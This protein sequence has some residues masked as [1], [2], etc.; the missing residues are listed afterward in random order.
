MVSLLRSLAF[1]IGTRQISVPKA[2]TKPPIHIQITSGRTKTLSVAWL[3]FNFAEAGENQIDIFAQA[4][5]MH[6]AADGR[7]LGR[8]KFQ[9]RGHD[10]FVVAIVKHA[11]GAFDAEMGRLLRAFETLELDPVVADIEGLSL[12][13]RVASFSTA[14][15]HRAGD[16][17]HDQDHAEMNHQAAVAP[18]IAPGQG[19]QTAQD[20]FAGDALA[21]AQRKGGVVKDRGHDEG[22]QGKAQKRQKVS[23]LPDEQQQ[24]EG[25]ERRGGPEK[26]ASSDCPMRRAAR[27]SSA[28]PP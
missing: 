13:A 8:K 17:H 22:E 28:R 12:T 24:T 27:R 19:N 5:L 15:G 4:A 3:R 20:T 14:V 7:L 18:L 21:R 10:A 26:I 6:G 23:D 9:R 16:A 2:M 1:P 25:S 11:K